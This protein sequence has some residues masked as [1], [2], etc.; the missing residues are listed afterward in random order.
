M[1]QQGD[2]PQQAFSKCVAEVTEDGYIKTKKGAK[3]YGG[4]PGDEINF[5]G[6]AN[7]RCI[8]DGKKRAPTNKTSKTDNKVSID[9]S[10]KKEFLK[11]INDARAMGRRCGDYGYFKAVP[12]LKWSDKL[13]LAAYR[14]SY[15]MAK[16]NY[17]SHTGS[18]K[19]TDLAAQA[20]HPG[21]GSSMKERINY[22][23]YKNWR[24]IGENIAAGTNM[25]TAKKA[26]EAWI[27]SP[28][29]CKNLMSPDFTEVGLAVVYDS[30]SHYKYYWTQD[31]GTRK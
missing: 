24:K 6:A 10:L 11:A 15:D 4:E 26:V 21:T 16:V 18:G 3:T 28:G 25:D 9:D 31:F 22:A 20:Y 7:I 29:H 12:P 23:E 17:F 14:H 30:N 2:T 5:S 8:S 27:N 19:K 1:N 13:Y